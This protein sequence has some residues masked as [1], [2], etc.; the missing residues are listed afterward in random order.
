MTRSVRRESAMASTTPPRSAS[1]ECQVRGFD[2]HIGARS[3]RDAHISL[4]QRGRVVDSVTDH[5]HHF[6]LGLQL[7]DLFRLAVGQHA[8]NDA[9]D[10]ATWR[11]FVRDRVGGGLMI[12]G[13]H[14]DLQ[15]QIL[16]LAEGSRRFRTW[17]IGQADNGQELGLGF[18]VQ[19]HH[20]HDG[21]GRRR[22]PFD[23]FL[24]GSG[25]DRSVRPA[26]ADSR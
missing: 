17:R 20:E 22:Q 13:Q 24:R 8:S 2:R 21:S 9:V 12:A 5:C 11:D 7:L 19:L 25:I 18:R 6:A 4:G 14:H 16:Q 26:D 10:L 23:G 1:D 15:S 3:D